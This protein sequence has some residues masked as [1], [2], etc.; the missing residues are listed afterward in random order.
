M[1]KG[2]ILPYLPDIPR[3]DFRWFLT[4]QDSNHSKGPK[5]MAEHDYALALE[6]RMNNSPLLKGKE[7]LRAAVNRCITHPEE[8][9]QTTW[10]CGTEHCIAG[11]C[12]VLA[13]YSET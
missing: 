3:P 10:H 1:R 9:R 6:R 12:Q 7:L 8:W 4:I 13:G 5:A 2:G 11:R